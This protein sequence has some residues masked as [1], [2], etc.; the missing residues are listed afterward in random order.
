M[1]RG[2]ALDPE[3]PLFKEWMARIY[4]LAG[5]PE[6]ARALLDTLL[7]IRERRWVAPSKIAIIYNDLG[8]TDSAVS[9]FEEA[10]AVRD[11]D[12]TYFMLVTSP[13]VRSH[14]RFQELRRRMNLA[15]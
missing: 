11:I 5:R 3:S 12:Q 9:W 14:P 2:Y 7:M 1:Q 15:P 10:Y 13:E 4:A 6:P 8:M